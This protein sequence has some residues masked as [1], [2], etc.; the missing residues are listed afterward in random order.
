[1]SDTETVELWFKLMRAS[2]ESE[3]FIKICE[4]QEFLYSVWNDIYP[5]SKLIYKPPIDLPE[6]L[7]D[8]I[9]V[10]ERGQELMNG[11][12]KG[13]GDEQ[14]PLGKKRG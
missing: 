3:K 5:D 10:L 9:K 11:K 13:C 7:R 1:M 2:E 12:F 8:P 14:K 6:S 4:A